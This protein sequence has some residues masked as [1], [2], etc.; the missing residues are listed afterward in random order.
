MNSAQP[1]T[2]VPESVRPVPEGAP[3][4]V[5]ILAPAD[6]AARAREVQAAVLAA[7]P[8]T[9]VTH[10]EP[11]G[12]SAGE[13][14]VRVQIGAGHVVIS[15]GEQRVKLPVDADP[16]VAAGVALAL[17]DAARIALERHDEQ[18]IENA[19]RASAAKLINEQQMETTLAVLVQRALLSPVP[20]DL[21]GVEAAVLYRPCA[22]LSG[23]LYDLVKLDEHHVAFFLADA[24]GHGVAAALLTMLIGR[25]LPMKDATHHAVRIVPP[26]E[27]MARLNSAYVQRQ[28]DTSRLITAIY[29]VLDLRTG[30]VTLASAG[31][32][33][34]AIVGPR[35]WRLVGDSGP[36]L[37][38]MENAEYPQAVETLVPGEAV[39]LYSDGF[40]WAF[41]G[42]SSGVIAQVHLGDRR[43]PNDR[44]LGAFA[45]LGARLASM[46][47]RASVDQM[48]ESMDRQSG[49]L[50]QPDDMTLVAVCLRATSEQA[51]AE[52]AAAEPAAAPE[53]ARDDRAGPAT[54]AA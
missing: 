40:E 2:N 16:R 12:P 15:G 18:R 10:G 4:G 17:L 44:Y 51:A 23:D 50:H 27:A 43:R 32:P 22:S 54:I 41:E 45:E 1:P 7:A 36:A 46:H 19:V 33:P 25:L 5:A 42:C 21:A 49:S 6:Q 8:G 30:Q 14:W 34:A 11:T 28:P 26:G 13:G 29:G 53:E 35:G 9:P 48:V 47:A 37:G 3:S 31:H 24:C 39:L 20:E 38:M 52:Q